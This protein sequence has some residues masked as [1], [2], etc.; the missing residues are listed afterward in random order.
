VLSGVERYA[1]GVVTGK[2][3]HVLANGIKEE[4]RNN[5]VVWCCLLASVEV[6]ISVDFIRFAF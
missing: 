2:M 1:D 3:L 6:Y 5:L 4:D